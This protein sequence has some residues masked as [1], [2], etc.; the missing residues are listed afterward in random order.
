MLCWL[1]FGEHEVP[2]RDS[3]RSWQL[4][5]ALL[6]V[7]GALLCVRGA[8]LCVQGALL[9]V[10]GAL[11]CVRGS[12]CEV[13]GTGPQRLGPLGPPRPQGPAWGPPYSQ[14]VVQCHDCPCGRILSSWELLGWILAPQQNPTVSSVVQ[15]RHALCGKICSHLRAPGLDSGTLG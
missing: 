11:L 3:G 5:E 8:L 6:C 4:R 9:C 13:S 15:I 14:S 1:A 2:K 12:L 10:Q 7:Q